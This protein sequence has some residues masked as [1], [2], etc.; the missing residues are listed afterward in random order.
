MIHIG[1]EYVDEQCNSVSFKLDDD[2]TAQG[3]QIFFGEL[4]HHE[5]K[6]SGGTKAWRSAFINS[7]FDMP[8][9]PMPGAMLDDAEVASALPHKTMKLLELIIRDLK[10]LHI[11]SG[12]AEDPAQIRKAALQSELGPVFTGCVEFG[13]QFHTERSKVTVQVPIQPEQTSLQKSEKK[14]KAKHPGLKS[15]IY[16][17]TGA[18]KRERRDILERPPQEHV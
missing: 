7:L 13:I 11:P 1:D 10:N 15:L 2:K 6:G 5:M 8:G 17:V 3:L 12:S 18:G 14:S 16:Q 4:K 9:T